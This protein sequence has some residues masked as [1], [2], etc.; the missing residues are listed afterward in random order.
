M[1]LISLR[2]LDDADQRTFLL[3]RIVSET[4]G[5]D[6]ALRFFHA[7]LDGRRE[8]DAF[9]DAPDQ[10]RVNA[11]ECAEK[12]AGATEL[13]HGA[14]AAFDATLLA[15]ADVYDWR[16]RFVHD[17]LRDDALSQRW[18][19]MRLNWKGAAITQTDFDD[20]VHLVE[21]IV[22]VTWRLRG[23]AL[24]VLQGGWESIALGE[25]E[26]QWDGNAKTSRGWS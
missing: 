15:A 4:A 25:V 13:A 19:L 26:G 11:R 5:L 3:G 17:L 8:V 12:V 20:M 1:D 6:A 16:N 7:A 22:G 10:F 9:R 21:E 18:E 14:R 23:S 24:Y 2:A